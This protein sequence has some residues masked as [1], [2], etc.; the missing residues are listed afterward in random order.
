MMTSASNLLAPLLTLETVRLG[1]D[2]AS[3]KRLYEEAGLMFE[4]SAGV[5][6]TEAF[7]ALFAREKLGST[8]LGAA[9]AIPH[10]RVSGIDKPCAVF[11]RT[12]APLALDAPDGRA[13]QLFLCILIPDSDS[14]DYLK[15]LRETAAFFSERANRT[16]LLAAQ[17]EVE[18]C[19]CIHNWQVPDDL[20]FEQDFAEGDTEET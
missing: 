15:I 9:C 5:P 20:H 16:A 2:V 1:L 18:V 4:S 10:G 7:D 6:H 3:R 19:E 12:A 14:D 17:S 11:L 8:C 13:V